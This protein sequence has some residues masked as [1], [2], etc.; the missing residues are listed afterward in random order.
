[1]PAHMFDLPKFK[2]AYLYQVPISM[3]WGEKKLNELCK[4]RIGVDPREGHAFLF[5]NTKRDCLKLFFYDAL[6]SNELQKLMPKGGFVLPAPVAGEHFVEITP[7]L[8]PRLF[9]R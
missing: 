8:V 6:G 9:S 1:M 5:F 7:S 4:G 3:R 2:K